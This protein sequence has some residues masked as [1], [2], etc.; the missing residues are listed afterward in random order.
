M[1]SKVSYSYIATFGPARPCSFDNTKIQEQLES[2][3][4]L[5]STSWINPHTVNTEGAIFLPAAVDEDDVVGRNDDGRQ[6]RRRL[7]F[8]S[9]RM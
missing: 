1:T 5:I 3:D 8:A 9:G 7:L 4:A 6:S 2:F